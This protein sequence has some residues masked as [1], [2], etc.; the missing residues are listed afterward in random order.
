MKHEIDL[1]KY[2][3]RTDLI[4]DTLKDEETEGILRN[5]QKYD[6]VLLEEIIIDEK[7]STQCGK[8][9]GI[10]KTITFDDITDSK[11]QQQVQKVFHDALKHL[12]DHH[13]IK[14]DDTC[15]IIGLGNEKSTPDSLGPLVIDHI[16][17]T[18][19]LFDLK[20]ATVE[21]GYRNVSCFA[22]GVTGTTGIE[23]QDFILG[24]IDKI[25]PHFVI[26]IDALASSSL[27][28]VNKVIQL[29]DTGIHPGSGVGNSRR[30]I[31]SETIGIPV[32]AIGIPT[33]VDAV[34]IVTDTIFYMIQNFSYN[35]ENLAKPKFKFIPSTKRNY[36]EHEENLSK[37]EKQNLLGL[38][39]NLNEEEMKT[40]VFEVL[41]PI[42]YNLMVT[43]KEIDFL[44]TKLSKVLARGINA[45]LH[46]Q[47]NP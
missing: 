6:N 11:N 35:K 31:S 12:L 28:R 23:T 3:Y 17:V 45:V 21:E 27:T 2:G 47:I 32:F 46:R 24:V 15:L 37:E 34:T 8:K 19:H 36:Q 22:P 33:V 4:V 43:P 29:T 39:G 30:E 10:Y 18:R 7:V 9:P 41:T 1:G 42:G 16:L 38:I 20:D 13:H 5:K 44:I 25:K 40:L 26:V 14:E